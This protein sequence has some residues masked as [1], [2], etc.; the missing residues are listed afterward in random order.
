MKCISVLGFD[1]KKYDNR[2]VN[3]DLY[4]L[5]EYY[6][7]KYYYLGAEGEKPE[8]KDNIEFIP[9][10]KEGK[11]IISRINYED[12]LVR[13]IISDKPDIVYLHSMFVFAAPRKIKRLNE[14]SQVIY[15]SHEYDPEFV[16]IGN[17]ILRDLVALHVMHSHKKVSKY[18]SGMFA[19]SNSNVQFYKTLG[20]SPVYQK[21]N[22][23]TFS[24][25]NAVKL[26]ERSKIIMVSGGWQ[27]ERGPSEVIRI[28]DGL[29][30]SE[31]ALELHLH[32]KM[33][34]GLREEIEAY[35]ELLGISERVHFLEFLP[36]KDLINK[37]S[38]V[39]FN[40]LSF[41]K[42]PWKTNY[43]AVPNRLFD[44]IGAGT[45]VLCSSD[46]IDVRE[47][48]DNNGVGY[49]FNV[50]DFDSSLSQL[51]DLIS[52]EDRYNA[53][54]SNVEQYS[55][56]MQWRNHRKVLGELFEEMSL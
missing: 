15:D 39:L 47:I 5:N 44:S 48:V 6:R 11:G 46:S 36:Y 9:V 43:I 37:M 16:A 21:M 2:I 32:V 50:H 35:I 1:H 17:K 34:A 7:I 28:F 29:L 38:V 56:A 49:S 24:N 31:P 27:Y 41:P 33:P 20:F 55:V 13:L 54:L 52:D 12:I 3:R 51:K 14:F 40:V 23:S 42:G 10:V 8:V 19:H 45:P 18:V 30:Q 26:S 4:T 22:V 53:I 25:D